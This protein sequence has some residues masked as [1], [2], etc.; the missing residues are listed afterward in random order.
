[1]KLTEHSQ[2]AAFVQ[3]HNIVLHED[4]GHAWLEVPLSL[5]VELGIAGKIS[6]Y[7][8]ICG[9]SAYLEEDCDLSVFCNAVGIGYSETE[10]LPNELRATFWSAVPNRYK[11]YTPIR[12]YRH[13]DTA[14]LPKANPQLLIF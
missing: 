8:Y 6:S 9:T 4:P 5:L 14:N 3:Q 7:S 10:T 1:M 13:F 12:S 2:I 11:E